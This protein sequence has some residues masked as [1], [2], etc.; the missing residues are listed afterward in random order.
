MK[1]ITSLV[2]VLF[3]LTFILFLGACADAQPEKKQASNSISANMPV[4]ENPV[5]AVKHAPEFSLKDMDGNQ[6]K[7]SDYK[8]KVVILDFW[9]TWCPPCVKEIPHFN[10]LAKKYGKDG[11]VVLGVSVDR[12]GI[13]AVKKFKKKTSID[14]TVVFSDASTQSNYQALLPKDMRGGIPYT[15]VIDRTGKVSDYYVGYRPMEVF[16]KAI[17]PLLGS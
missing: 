14:Y 7:L 16:V 12:G 3:T 1:K 9:A 15:F 6:V 8:G 10:D 4:A 11:L 17:T 5:K 2:T 13:D